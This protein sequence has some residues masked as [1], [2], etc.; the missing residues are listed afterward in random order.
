MA[1]RSTQPI[2]RQHLERVSWQVLDAYRDLLQSMIRGHAG[3]YALYKGERLYYVGLAKNLMGRVNH[4]LRDRHAKRWDRFSV[5]LTVEDDHIRSLEALVLRIAQPTGNRVSGK[6]R[7]SSDLHRVLQRAM[8]ERD[9]D[10]RAL[11]LGGR[12]VRARRKRKSKGA[13]GTRVLAGVVERPINLVGERKVEQFRAKLGRDGRIRFGGQY[14]DSP[15]GA[16]I[17]AIGRAINGWRFWHY[18]DG[19]RGWRPLAN[20]RR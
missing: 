1:R 20:L 9:A 15:S 10:R 19:H 13:K 4:H 11:L 14:F 5:Y 16:G 3:V 18:R 8:S 17:A 7:S 2:V 12:T 6:L